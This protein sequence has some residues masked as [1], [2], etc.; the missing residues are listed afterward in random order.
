MK[1][2]KETLNT[3]PEEHAKKKKK[4]RVDTQIRSSFSDTSL[5]AISQGGCDLNKYPNIH[6]HW[7]HQIPLVQ[8]GGGA[9]GRTYLCT[10]FLNFGFQEVFTAE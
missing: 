2:G 8:H 6:Q 1:N 5:H 7:C 4:L 10:E 3:H 9:K